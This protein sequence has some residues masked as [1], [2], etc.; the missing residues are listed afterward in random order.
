MNNSR[1]F[2][3]LEMI[4]ATMIMGIAVAGLLSGISGATRNA[5]HLRDYDRVVQMA[6]FR[7]NELLVDPRLP[8]N[9]LLSGTFDPSM[10]GGLEAG[11][12]AQATMFELP[13]HPAPGLL[14]LEQIRLQVWWMAGS[15]RRTL[16]L[17]C[18]RKRVL[19]EAD[20]PV[21]VTP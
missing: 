10:T 5:A 16:D 8:Q 18:L 13:P 7:M 9:A 15:E 1:G 17:E 19:Q 3:L 4:V 21:V 20:I 2:T 12:Q 6:R 14:G 11:W